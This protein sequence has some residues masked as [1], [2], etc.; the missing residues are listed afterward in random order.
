[1]I[2]GPAAADRNLIGGHGGNGVRLDQAGSNVV[3]NNFVG[4]D[5]TGT[6][7]AGNGSDGIAVGRS[8]GNAILDNLIADNFAGIFLAYDTAAGN[9][10]QGNF[11]G[12]TPGGTKLANRDD[13]ISDYGAPDNTIGGPALA[14][15]NVI[16]GNAQQGL[17]LRGPGATRNLVQG[18]LI[19]L[20]PDGRNIVGNLQNGI[21]LQ[22]APGNTIGGTT[23]GAGN[24]SSGNNQ[25]GLALSYYPDS[26]LPEGISLDLVGGGAPRLQPDPGQLLRHRPQRQRA[27]PRQR[28]RR[29]LPRLR[30]AQ[31]D[32][33][34][35]PRR[36]QPPLRQRDLRP[37][38]RRPDNRRHEREQHPR[39][40]VQPRPGQQ[41][42]HRRQRPRRRPQPP[43]RHLYRRGQRQY[44]RRHRRRRGQRDLGQ[45]GAGPPDQRRHPR[46]GRLHRQSRP[47][48]PHRPRHQP[49]TR[50]SPT[51]TPA[52]PPAT[53]A[54]AS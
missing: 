7:P 49:A 14:D 4:V 48:Q 51:P 26:L 28:P 13:G 36:R 42:R 17:S 40:V 21:F 41:D 32:R 29:D 43:A 30:S 54:M 16:S 44:D 11:L 8:P 27:K 47:G 15:R 9:L 39:G 2:G 24:I 12:I 35:R 46:Q 25:A 33:W 34:H 23:P 19:G 20:T 18:N 6:G 37:A 10:I 38:H 52:C 3:Q 50:P 22:N 1:M 53:S 5:A 31:H 45:Q